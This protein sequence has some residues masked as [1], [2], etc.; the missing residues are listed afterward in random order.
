MNQVFSQMVEDVKYL[1]Q[2]VCVGGEG[3]VFPIK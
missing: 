3:G 1:L 2:K